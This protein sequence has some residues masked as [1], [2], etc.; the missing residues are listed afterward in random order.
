[1]TNLHWEILDEHRQK[2]MPKLTF[3]K[4]KFYL[5]G[6]TA[7]ALYLGHRDSVDFDFFSPD[8]F[9]LRELVKQIK[10]AFNGLSIQEI[11]VQPNTLILVIDGVN[12]SF[13]K[14]E[15]PMLEPFT[16]TEHL[17]LA[18]LSDIGCMKLGAILAR[19]V[20]KDY[21]DLYAICK[22]HI[23]LRELL[24]KAKIKYPHM[25]TS[26]F[27]RAIAYYEDLQITPILFKNNFFVDVETIKKFFIKEVKDLMGSR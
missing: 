22:D 24:D 12:M 14:L 5:A 25:D 16:E 4:D 9:D 18:S 26:A 19:Y 21:V 3:L 6:G 1:M 23:P 8:G 15:E 27:I 10:A 17:K 11:N 7:I 2:F 20:L 13:F